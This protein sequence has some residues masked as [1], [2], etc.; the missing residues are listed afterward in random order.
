MLGNLKKR[1]VRRQTTDM[2][3]ALATHDSQIPFDSATEWLVGNYGT[4]GQPL[5]LMETSS[6]SPVH[7]IIA[8]AMLHVDLVGRASRRS[9]HKEHWRSTST[10]DFNDGRVGCADLHKHWNNYISSA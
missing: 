1:H 4:R 2:L 7:K 5:F 6:A 9:L 10:I 3:N 8:G